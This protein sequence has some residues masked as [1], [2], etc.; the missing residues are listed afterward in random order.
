[1]HVSDYT[2]VI[3]TLDRPVLLRRSLLDLFQ[4]TE[5]P[6]QV[7]VVD[8]SADDATARLCQ[9]LAAAGRPLTWQR[10][11]ARSAARQRN[12]GAAAATT[13]LIGFVDDDVELPPDLFVKLLAP[14]RHDIAGHVGGVSGR[15][16]GLAHHPPSRLLRLYYRCQAG[17]AHP[18][19]AGRLFGAGINC[20]PC[21]DE[22]EGAEFAVEWLNAGCTL[23]R[24]ELF[25]RQQFPNF[26]EYSFME[27]AHLSWRIGRTHRLLSI[28][29]AVYVHIGASS[30]FKRDHV[31]LA[32][33]RLRHRRM[34]A[35]DLL[36][37]GP[38]RLAW[39]FFLARVFETSVL[40]RARPPG[41]RAALRGVWS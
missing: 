8:A 5:P 23:F 14:F 35:R 13:A 37:L 38:V 26:D 18:T 11:A 29:D 33:M 41:W 21:Y 34:V 31:A 32:R 4:Q 36:G 6:A 20:L 40:L 28:R 24:R 7:I 3:A 22:A 2:I 12:Q 30:N 1:M 27:D 16:A 9:E 15:I 39:L 10:A 25:E 17:Y 19:Y